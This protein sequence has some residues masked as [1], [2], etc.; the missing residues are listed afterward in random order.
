MT[1][2]G[3]AI[4]E[5]VRRANPVPANDL[6]APAG[7]TR[8][9][10]I[11]RAIAREPAPDRPVARRRRVLGRRS[12]ALA[13]VGVLVVGGLAAAAIR[14]STDDVPAQGNG[15]Y[16]FS[17]AVVDQ[18]PQ[19]YE[20]VRPARIGELPERP[21]LLFG[22]GITYTQAVSR[23][24]D[25]REAGRVVPDGVE[26]VDPL[27]AGISVRVRDD[28]RVLLDPAAPLGWDLQ[29]RLVAGA[30]R[31]PL[32]FL[33]LARCQVILPGDDPSAQAR[34]GPRRTEPF[35]TETDGR[36]TAAPAQG[37][38]LP[39]AIV[40][41]TD[42]SVLERPRTSADRLPAALEASLRRSYAGNPTGARDYDLD[43][44]DSRFAGVHDGSR[45]YVIP[46]RD[47]DTVCLQVVG[48]GA[49]VGSTC[50]PRLTLV[51]FGAIPLIQAG[52]YSGL[53]GDGYDRVDV[54]GLGSFPIRDNVF[55]VPLP[56]RPIKAITLSGPLGTHRI[57]T[58]GG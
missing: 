22:P 44:D 27:P 28:G 8:D 40:G 39:S 52:R 5:R 57:S 10:R 2:R 23:Y 19:G 48:S 29:T 47:G 41:S 1:R 11:A 26:L 54:P 42:L 30:Y 55:S 46:L 49:N 43:Y 53:V 20:R 21:A 50:N 13:L 3:R 37:T 12:G 7:A 45:I 36:W 56:E 31:P 14:W 4:G 25:A 58:L 38:T 16:A 17:A 9:E 6:P 33:T 32:R 34:C 35:V 18:L 15:R 51:T 24:F